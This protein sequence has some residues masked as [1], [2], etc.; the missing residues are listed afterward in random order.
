[1]TRLG[2]RSSRDRVYKPMAKARGARRESEGGVVPVIA[3]PQNAVGGK[4]P[5][6][7]DASGA[8]KSEGM[9]R[10]AASKHPDG[11][12]AIDKVRRLQR[13]LYMAAKR[14]RRRRFHA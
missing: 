3:A 9:V 6:F 10:T 7:G 2:S 5:C 11:P 1:E 4:A 14:D 13:K 12:K 8:G